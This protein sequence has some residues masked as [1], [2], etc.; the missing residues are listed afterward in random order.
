MKYHIGTACLETILYTPYYQIFWTYHLCVDT[1]NHFNT[2]DFS[3][4]WGGCFNKCAPQKSQVHLLAFVAEDGTFLI[5]WKDKQP[6]IQLWHK[7]YI[8][9]G[10]RYIPVYLL[11]PVSL[12]KHHLPKCPNLGNTL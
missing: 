11:V 1:V 9:R 6:K 8:R 3:F 12:S 5:R 7:V 10:R 2:V 4:I